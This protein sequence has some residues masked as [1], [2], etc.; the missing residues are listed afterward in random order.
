MSIRVAHLT[1]LWKAGAG[2]VVRIHDGLRGRG[3]QSRLF[4]ASPVDSS[5]ADAY[6][7]PLIGPNAQAEMGSLV[8][9]QPRL[10]EPSNRT[11][12][13]IQSMFRGI[14]ASS[15]RRLRRFVIGAARCR[16]AAPALGGLLS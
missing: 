9:P 14:L 15:C 7:L 12:R 13:Q 10:L 16:R 5:L 2:A 11:R 4:S 3:V 1:G 6:A 8:W